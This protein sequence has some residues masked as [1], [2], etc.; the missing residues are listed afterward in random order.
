MLGLALLRINIYFFFASFESPTIDRKS[1]SSIA[2]V[3]SVLISALYHPCCNLPRD[4]AVL[5]ET[6]DIL[7]V[8]PDRILESKLCASSGNP[9]TP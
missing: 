2:S 6:I 5:L 4:A 1:T 9:V 3:D 8:V 7:Q